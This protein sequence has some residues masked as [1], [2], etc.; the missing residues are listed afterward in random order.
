M[1]ASTIFPDHP[2]ATPDARTFRFRRLLAS[3]V[4][5]RPAR[6]TSL[7]ISNNPKTESIEQKRRLWRKAE[8]ILVKGQRAFHVTYTPR[9][10]MHSVNGERMPCSYHNRAYILA[11]FAS[12]KLKAQHDYAFE[13]LAHLRS[14]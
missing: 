14:R 1:A 8:D 3:P 9:H 13:S 4:S 10:V 7:P 11:G 5:F 6:Y 2:C 12:W